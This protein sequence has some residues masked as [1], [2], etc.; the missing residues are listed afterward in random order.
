MTTLAFSTEG[1]IKDPSDVG[2]GQE[3]EGPTVAPMKKQGRGLKA[4]SLNTKLGEDVSAKKATDLM[5][6]QNP[7]L[8]SKNWILVKG[9]EKKETTRFHFTA[10]VD[11]A[12]QALKQKRQCDY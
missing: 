3:T 8:N 6:R 10:L 4:Y 1:Q 12:M 11:R 7:G 5:D 9:N 2:Y